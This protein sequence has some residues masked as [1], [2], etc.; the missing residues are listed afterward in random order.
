MFELKNIAF[1]N[2]TVLFRAKIPGKAETNT[3][4][5]NGNVTIN[6]I[7]PAVPEIPAHYEVSFGVGFTVAT[8]GLSSAN[9]LQL[10]LV[11][12]DDSD[13]ASYRSVEDRAARLVA[14][15]LR[16]LADKVEAGLPAFD[17]AG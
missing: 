9:Y 8:E 1:N 7:T 2:G 10:N 4:E 12:A 16:S 11:I 15:M 17:Q 3:T 6:N 13:R 5:K 14:P